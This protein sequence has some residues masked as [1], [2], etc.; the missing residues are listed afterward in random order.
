[1]ALDQQI[2]WKVYNLAEGNL[3]KEME[4]FSFVEELVTKIIETVGWEGMGINSE[5]IVQSELC[6]EFIEKRKM[7]CNKKR[8][9]PPEVNDN[10][11]NKET[12]FETPSK[13]IRMRTEHSTETK[14]IYRN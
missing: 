4:K 9:E 5:I 3:C 7:S 14:R 12:D 8:K 11:E 10:G 1:M 13:K 6:W 2:G